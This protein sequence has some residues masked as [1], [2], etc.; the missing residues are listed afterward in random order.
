MKRRILATSILFL[1]VVV[2]YL[3]YTS[4]RTSVPYFRA[5]GYRP[6]TSE[7]GI[8]FYVNVIIEVSKSGEA[9]SKV[10]GCGIGAPDHPLKVDCTSPGSGI[11]R[12]QDYGDLKTGDDFARI[13]RLLFTRTFDRMLEM[14]GI[15]RVDHSTRSLL[16]TEEQ[17][18]KM[19]AKV[20]NAD[21]DPISSTKYIIRG[22]AFDF[23]PNGGQGVVT[24]YY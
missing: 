18:H 19:K 2:F 10:L 11:I 16:A 7:D 9:T 8:G 3:G 22:T 5:H 20:A 15:L 24:L 21:Q 13:R 17:I 12:A 14:D 1:A 23:I 4:Y 6:V